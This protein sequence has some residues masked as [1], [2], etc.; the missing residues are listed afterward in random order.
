V[1][2]TTDDVETTGWPTFAAVVSLLLG[3]YHVMSGIAAINEDDL[4]ENLHEVLYGINLTTWGWFWV[5]L[6][7]IQIA[8]AFLIF[9]RKPLGYFLGVAGA[10][11]SSS[12]TV[13]LI[14]V[15]PIWAFTV[16]FV[17]LLVIY[18]LTT[19]DEEFI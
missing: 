15:A 3:I 17:N 6:G 5:I 4:T 19:H 10:L 8:V 14:F 13:F 18:G 7:V 16:L 1:T 11:V 2:T 12:L 9:Q